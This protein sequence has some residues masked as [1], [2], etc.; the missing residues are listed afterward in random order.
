[1]RRVAS[2][3][4]TCYFVGKPDPGASAVKSD[5]AR[6]LLQELQARPG[7]GLVE[8]AGAAGLSPAATSHHVARLEAA[9]LLAAQRDGRVRRLYPT[10]SAA[11]ASAGLRVEGSASAA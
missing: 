4:Y 5:G 6:R 7:L 8:L 2:G 9:G 11:A 3:G 10:A 1:V